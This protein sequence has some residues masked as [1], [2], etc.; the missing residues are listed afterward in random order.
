MEGWRELKKAKEKLGIKNNWELKIFELPYVT[1][2]LAFLILKRIIIISEVVPSIELTI[3]Q[4]N[5]RL[6]EQI[7]FFIC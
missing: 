3:F 5:I 7:T 2:G 6:H 4:K 1:C